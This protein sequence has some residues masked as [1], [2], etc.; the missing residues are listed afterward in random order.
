MIDNYY[1]VYDHLNH[2]LDDIVTFNDT[3]LINEIKN[4][5]YKILKKSEVKLC[6]FNFNDKWVAINVVYKE[7]RNSKY[8]TVIKERSSK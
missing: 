1:K 3:D 8:I 6:S 2:W 5:N 7:N 4:H